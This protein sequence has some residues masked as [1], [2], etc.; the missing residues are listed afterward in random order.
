MNTKTLFSLLLASV[1]CFTACDGGNDPENKDII[2]ENQE[3]L[4]QNVSADAEQSAVSFTTTGA[5]TSTITESANGTS[6]QKAVASPSWI[7]ITPDSGKEAGD[8]TITLN[9]SENTTGADRTAT[10]TIIC[11]ETAVTITVTQKGTTEEG[12]PDDLVITGRVK[13]INGDNIVY[14]DYN[15]VT[16]IGSQKYGVK[17]GSYIEFGDDYRQIT[18]RLDYQYENRLVSKTMYSIWNYNHSPQRD[19]DPEKLETEYTWNGNTLTH[20]RGILRGVSPYY[21]LSTDLEYGNIYAKPDCNIDI[22]W[23]LATDNYYVLL[24]ISAFIKETPDNVPLLAKKTQ[25]QE[26]SDGKYDAVITY[27]YVL[28]ENK[29]VTEI[30]ET[31]T[32]GGGERLMYEIEYY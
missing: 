17:E 15:S 9:L 31:S 21:Y 4:T 30:Y 24:P 20:I 10:I 11:G 12:K 8:Y 18:H 32:I 19:P 29:Y 2:V 6:Q 23:L 22:N 1:L 5:W 16:Q 25:T 27:R 3:Q 28:N 13:K 7:S 26:A 14:D